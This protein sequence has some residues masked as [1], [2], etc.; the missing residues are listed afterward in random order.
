VRPVSRRV[1]VFWI[2]S[3]ALAVLAGAWFHHLLTP[4]T[5]E[6]RV[7]QEA[8]KIKERIHDLTH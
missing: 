5:T 4:E 1:L 7:R 8:E 6:E 3:L 2:V